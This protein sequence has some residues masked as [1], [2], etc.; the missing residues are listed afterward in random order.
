MDETPRFEVLEALEQFTDDYAILIANSRARLIWLTT[1]LEKTAAKL[2][3]VKPGPKRT[4]LVLALDILES[5]QGHVRRQLTVYQHNAA[6]L[7]VRRAEVT[8]KA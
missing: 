8:R 2:Q 3:T 5:H 4:G 6:A 1:A 7:T